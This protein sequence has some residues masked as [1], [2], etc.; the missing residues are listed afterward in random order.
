MFAADSSITLDFISTSQ[1]YQQQ[2]P[3]HCS[4]MLVVLLVLTSST[5][6]GRDAAA[7]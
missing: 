4:A 3:R 1:E 5:K 2:C 7:P 6:R